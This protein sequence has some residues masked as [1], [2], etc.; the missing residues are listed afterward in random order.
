MRIE[1]TNLCS[2]NQFKFQEYEKVCLEYGVRGF[3]V[4]RLYGKGECGDQW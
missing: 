4:G 3:A 2:I 1:R